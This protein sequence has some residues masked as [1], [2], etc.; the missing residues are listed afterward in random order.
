MAG[1][2]TAPAFLSLLGS[3]DAYVAGL[4]SGFQLGKALRTATRITLATAFAHRSG[5]SLLSP[6]ISKSSATSLRLI[7]GLNFCRTEPGVLSDWLRLGERRPVDA[8]LATPSSGRVFHPK[9]LLVDAPTSFAI[10][11]SG[12]LSAGGLRDNFECG[13]YTRDSTVLNALR[14][15]TDHLCS[16]QISA[17]LD[18]AAIDAYLPKYR[19]AQRD[20]KNA[21]KLQRKAEREIR[22]HADAVMIRWDAAV[23][24]ARR[25]FK[26]AGFRRD[27]N[28]EWRSGASQIRR[29]L[30]AP[31]FNFSKEEWREFYSILPF[32]HL[33]ALNRDKAFRQRRRLQAGLRQ[34]APLF[35]EDIVEVPRLDA[36]L[37]PDGKF[38]VSGVGLNVVS[39][40]LAVHSPNRWPVYN[41]AVKTALSRF[42]Y[43]P[44]RGAS[45]GAKYLS[46]ARLMRKFRR[47]TGAPSLLALDPFFYREYEKS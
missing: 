25:Y 23:S 11:G 24:Q 44:P 13:L 20:L 17:R 8:Y 6:H 18:Q 30:H 22:E 3:G 19:A 38:Y 28:G 40:V 45:A 35:D 21:R 41:G 42:G 32:G 7:A 2:K 39:K 31:S 14:Q 10:V 46:F 26:G 43:S 15:W 5:W 29:T 36:V 27:W 47:E 33:I 37:E 16:E 34:L 4:P 12:N 1:T 9:I